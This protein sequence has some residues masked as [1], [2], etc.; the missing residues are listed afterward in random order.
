[1]S[2]LSKREQEIITALYRAK[3]FV[4][5]EEIAELLKV[6][7]KTVY[8]E[9]KDISAKLEQNVTIEKCPGKGF[10][11]K[12]MVEESSREAAASAKLLELPTTKVS[13]TY[14]G[15]REEASPGA[16]GSGVSRRTVLFSDVSCSPG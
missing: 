2:E 6:S 14:L 10:R 11:L 12:Q 1:M 13:N 9:V 7:T 3:D 16:M 15:F 4:S 8:R 5:A